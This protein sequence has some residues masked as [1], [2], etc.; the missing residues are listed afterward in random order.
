MALEGYARWAATLSAMTLVK[1]ENL[2]PDL[3][4][5]ERY[6]DK[7]EAEYKAE[8]RAAG[9]WKS[10]QV[11][12][13]R[14][15][16][17]GVFL[18]LVKPRDGLKFDRESLQVTAPPGPQPYKDIEVIGRGA[19]AIWNSLLLEGSRS[20]VIAASDRQPQHIP[21]SFRN[22]T[23]WL[24]RG[25]VF[26]AEPSLTTGETAALI[27]QQEVRKARAIKR[28]LAAVNV[29]RDDAGKR[30][31]IPDEVKLFVWQRD[32][33]RCVKCGE[34]ANLEFD[35]VIPPHDGWEQH[36]QKHPVAL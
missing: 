18:R 12:R 17:V 14:V 36:R 16:G 10:H 35:H 25:E 33:G 9:F 6:V 27:F 7:S 34:A 15:V 30:V 32:Q 28:A 24:Y 20:D 31:P 26:S 4:Q 1:K 5:R 8:V 21:G 13:S 29:E 22:R 23:V 11:P 3:V 2:W 19:S